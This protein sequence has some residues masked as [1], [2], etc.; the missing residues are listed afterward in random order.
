MIGTTGREWLSSFGEGE[1]RL[2]WGSGV[3]VGE[4]PGNR[5]LQR[6][7]IVCKHA[8]L[9]QVISCAS[10]IPC[11]I[12]VHLQLFSPSKGTTYNPRVSSISREL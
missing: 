9:D 7:I 8:H 2:C 10:G 1:R 5:A 12:Q 4:D 6:G 11:S 3:L